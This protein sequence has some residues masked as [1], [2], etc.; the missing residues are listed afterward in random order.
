[1]L[2]QRRGFSYQ[3]Q[4][5]QLPHHKHGSYALFESFTDT[6]LPRYT[7]IIVGGLILELPLYSK[8]GA[9][10]INVAGPLGFQPNYDIVATTLIAFRRNHFEMTVSP[11]W[12]S[13]HSIWNSQS[14][15][16][17]EWSTPDEL[18][19][20]MIRSMAY[21]AVGKSNGYHGYLVKHRIDAVSV[22][23]YDYYDG[24][25]VLGH[26]YKGNR[27]RINGYDQAQINRMFGTG[28]SMELF[29]RSMSNLI[30]VFHHST[31]NY[32][33]ISEGKFITMAKY[34][35]PIGLLGAAPSMEAYAMYTEMYSQFM[36][37]LVRSVVILVICVLFGIYSCSTLIVAD[38]FIEAKT[39]GVNHGIGFVVIAAVLVVFG[40]LLVTKLKKYAAPKDGDDIYVS[41]MGFLT[42]YALCNLVW[43]PIALNFSC[44]LY[45]VTVTVAM[46]LVVRKRATLEP[47]PVNDDG[48]EVLCTHPRCALS[49]VSGI[50]SDGRT[51][52]DFSIVILSLSPLTIL[53]IGADIDSFD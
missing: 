9:L 30:E 15:T 21:Q 34:F 31:F 38:M 14:P 6:I 49:F 29:V 43:L 32:I 1:M 52:V 10:A 25:F 17:N 24:H 8:S 53:G 27:A 51:K 37:T 22:V 13:S 2:I 11:Y 23:S 41:F 35:I 20:S 36:G 19:K 16:R 48:K 26:K 4:Q 50:R 18:R 12:S 7:S 39:Q 44:G 28:H 47:V 45:F 33:V 40:V 3:Y 5:N 46:L 42:L